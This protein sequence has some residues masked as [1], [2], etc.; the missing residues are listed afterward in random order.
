M[1]AQQLFSIGH[2]NVPVARL[3]VLL[4]QHH[5]GVV[6]DVRS[7]PYSR[8]NPQFNRENLA[9]SLQDQ[10]IIYRFMG[11]SLGG[12]PQDPMLFSE[13]G[14][15]PDYIKIAAS[16]TFA[17]SIERLIGLGTQTRTAFMCGEADYRRCPRHVLVTPALI[18][19]GITVWHILPDG[20]LVRG[21]AVPLQER[22]F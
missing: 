6:C 13:D 1:E 19:R 10:D 5:I 11:E 20:D 8:Y 9:T 12:K 21:V 16:P 14:H 22:M 18:E 3:I 17:R 15:T 2:S 7:A 4:Q